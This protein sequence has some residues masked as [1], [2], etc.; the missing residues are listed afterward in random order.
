MTKNDFLK[1]FYSAFAKNIVSEEKKHNVGI[2]KKGLL[3]D[4]FAAKLVS[5]YEGDEARRLFDAV[6]KTGA[7]EIH[8]SGNNRFFEDDI[9]T[10]DLS[11]NHIQ[12]KGID[13]SGLF[14]FYAIGRDFE[15]C[16]IVTH[17]FDL[18]GPYFCFK[19]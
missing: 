7:M 2:S 9:T 18:C 5:C 17:E 12:A 1:A 16:Y 19:Q 8:Y 15:W 13:N 6:D 4:I 10:S 11:D 3:W 14:E